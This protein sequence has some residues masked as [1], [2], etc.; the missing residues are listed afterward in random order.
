MEAQINS[1]RGLTRV[2]F[3]EMVAASMMLPNPNA[4][5][6]PDNFD[7]LRGEVKHRLA[8]DGPGGRAFFEAT[9]D[10]S[11]SEAR[12]LME[13]LLSMTAMESHVRPLAF[14]SA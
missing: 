3:E 10:R 7:W 14:A 1:L 2:I 5:W 4:V 9:F 6:T 11:Y 12:H 8:P 13:E